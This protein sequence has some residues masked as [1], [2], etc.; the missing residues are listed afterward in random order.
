METYS[1]LWFHKS[2]ESLRNVIGW[3]VYLLSQYQSNTVHQL[4]M[5]LYLLRTSSKIQNMSNT[6]EIVLK[7]R[8]REREKTEQLDAH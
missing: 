6:E 8:E 4:H 1:T 7:E 5:S 2:T 3:G